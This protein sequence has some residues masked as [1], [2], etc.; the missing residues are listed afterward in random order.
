MLK[1]VRFEIYVY[2]LKIE[3]DKFQRDFFGILKLDICA[4]STANIKTLKFTCKA[5]LLKT[6]V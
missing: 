3:A 1:G 2:F 6:F 5:Y 4:A